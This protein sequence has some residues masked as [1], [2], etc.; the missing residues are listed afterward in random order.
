MPVRRELL[1]SIPSSHLQRLIIP[2]DVLIQ[3][4]PLMMSAVMLE[5]CR[6]VK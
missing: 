6:D 5:T 1:T 4:D 3:F 2:V